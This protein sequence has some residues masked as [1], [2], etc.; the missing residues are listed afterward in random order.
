M[1]AVAIDRFGG[2]EVV[3]T[4]QLPVPTP[5]EHEILLRVEM[6]GVGA[7]DPWVREGRF[8]DDSTQ[9]PYVMGSDGAGVVVAVGP[10]VRRLHVG[11]RVWGFQLQGGFHAE[12]VKLHEDGAALIPKGLDPQEAGALGADGITA[13]RGLEDQLQLQRGESLMIIGASGGIGHMAV[14]LAK[15]NGARVLAVASRQDGVEFVKR[16]GADVALDGRS[17]D[18]PAAVRRAAP[19]GVESALVLAGGNDVNQALRV[20]K[21]GGRIA[22]PHGI[23]P[24]PEAPKAVQLL[25]YDGLPS[26]EAFARLNQ[27]IGDAPFHVELSK[28]YDLDQGARAHQ[29]IG[30]HH[31]GK[32]ALRIS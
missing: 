27:L 12:Y 11:D 3:H 9:F 16:L 6:A 4:A 26:V 31:L 18:L 30:E 20:V 13:L 7:W 17:D 21:E 32:R 5:G 23:E 24:E 22:Y 1:T 2:P 19:E 28:I 10:E 15:R 25:A 14:Q 8:D 29:E